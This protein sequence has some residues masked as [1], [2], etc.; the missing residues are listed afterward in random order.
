ME[1]KKCMSC[2]ACKYMCPQG[3]IKIKNNSSG[4]NVRVID[5]AKCNNCSLCDKNCPLNH[6][7]PINIEVKAMAGFCKNEKDRKKASSG[8]LFY[9]LAKDIIKK[10]GVVYGA[11]F[12]KNFDV[13]HMRATTLSEVKKMR[14]SKYVQSD[15]GDSLIKVR[16]DLNQGR[17]VLFSGTPCQIAGLKSFL[18]K[19]YEKLITI[20]IVCHGAPSAD[21]WRKYINELEIE[22]KSK[23]VNIQFRNKKLGW[24]NPQMVIEFENKEKIS[25]AVYNNIFGQAFLRN[26]ILQE[27]C[28]VCNFNCFRNQSDITLGDFWGYEKE[29][30]NVDFSNGLS[31]I[32]LNTDR[33]NKYINEIKLDIQFFENINIRNAILGNYPF[34]HSSIPHYNRAKVLKEL[35]IKKN[36]VST[37]IMN[38]LDEMNGLKKT[39]K[40]VAIL[41]FSFENY[42]YGANLVAYSLSEIVKKLEY[43]RRFTK[44]KINKI[45]VNKTGGIA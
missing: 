2:T 29:I 28:Y 40:G 44:N 42:N 13:V 1:A 38:N 5:K 8:G 12:D 43:I 35:A 23:I 32:L 41:N 24:Q 37:I 4:M 15:L 20:D 25:S 10:N 26:M 11:C 45:E 16:E 27:T 17:Y 39:K 30:N 9:Y 6:N 21:I 3:A 7:Y 36:N 19:D 18:A 31:L 14:G 34:I 22:Y 33:G